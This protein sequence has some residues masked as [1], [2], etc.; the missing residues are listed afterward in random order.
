[1]S[2]LHEV[3]S[4]SR[5]ADE[6][7]KPHSSHEATSHPR[8]MKRNALL[9]LAA[10]GVVFGDIGT[11]P[12]YVLRA[13]FTVHDGAVALNES[14]I[15]G[16]ISLIIW[17]LIIIVTGKYVLNVL[18][19]DYDGEGGISAMV[20]LVRSRLKARPKTSTY[21]IYVGMFGAALFFGDSV[22]TPAISVLSA[23]EGT[24]VAMPDLSQS[25]VV[26]VA[27]GILIA[28]FSAQRFGTE[29]VGHVF[30]PIMACWFIVLAAIGIP[31]ILHNPAIIRALSPQYAI[32]FIAY[33]PFVAFVALGAIVLAV[34]GAEALYAD[35][36]HFGRQPITGA[37]FVFVLPS[38][39]INYLGQGA[40]L[41]ADM[42]NVRD[43]FFT[44]VPQSYALALTLLATVATVIAAQAVIAGSY[45]VARQVSRLGYLPHLT[46]RH[47]SARESTQVY[48]PGV[49]TLLMVAVSCV[50]IIFQ[51]SE[52][53][54]SAYGLAVSTDFLLTTMLLITV[55]HLVWRWKP[56]WTVLMGGILLCIEIP[57]FA[58]NCAKIFTGGWLPL[59]IASAL[60][61][62]MTT[63]RRG[64]NIITAKRA[65]N[66]GPLQD[67]LFLLEKQPPRRIPGTAIYPHS[68]INTA[69]FA[70]KVNTKINR[71]LHDHV[72][73]LSLKTA[74]RPYIAQEDRVK[75]ERLSTQGVVHF[76]I[77]YGFM[78][79]RNVPEDLLWAQ[80]EFGLTTWKLHQ[81][82]W[83]LSHIDVQV[84]KKSRMS[85]LRTKL[86]V[87]LSKL[88][89]SPQWN[90]SLP[91]SRT[92]EL[93]RTVAI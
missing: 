60:M 6:K 61:I 37:W 56:V 93:A 5:G 41:L 79:S 74:P 39:C 88:S 52:R 69:P 82:T 30:G 8:S 4:S 13:V 59:V 71:A 27:L 15:Y 73:I 9:G 81:A 77:T 70:L 22:I 89:A 32:A 65:A 11:S 19:A 62:V 23:I 58:A 90:K 42:N 67:F 2:K 83:M 18:R 54:S 84:A 10:L 14:N 24:L 91:R 25:F 20:T 64:E 33:H 50:I 51:D 68:L 46:V 86:F 55:T 1:M 53:L 34:T 44:M 3:S 36:A 63:W 38:L 28:L 17:V 47:T 35:I 75:I 87:F 85:T 92:L 72:I 66:E 31:H 29:K 21:L 57:L 7:K 45:S 26:P 40:N 16:V 12:L 49:N 48:L 43:P 78:D 80:K 76:T